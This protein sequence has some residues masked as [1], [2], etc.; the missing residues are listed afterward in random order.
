MNKQQRTSNELKKR[1]KQIEIIW[2]TVCTIESL[3]LTLGFISID[4]AV[5]PEPVWPGPGDH[6]IR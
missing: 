5:M 1:M 6:N 2:C 3:D 4:L